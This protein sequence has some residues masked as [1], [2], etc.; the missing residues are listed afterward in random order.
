MVFT[1]LFTLFSST[2]G[3][4]E[5]AFRHYGRLL[6]YYQVPNDPS[7]EKKCTK[8]SQQ[9][10]GGHHVHCELASKTTRNVSTAIFREQSKCDYLAEP[11]Q[12]FYTIYANAQDIC[13]F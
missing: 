11:F 6:E 7:E 12:G 13:L 8:Y 3:F 9:C 2:L 1:A 4:K 10:S 5:T